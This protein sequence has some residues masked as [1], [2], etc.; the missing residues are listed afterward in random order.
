M[1]PKKAFQQ[2]RANAKQRGIPFEMTFDD[3]WGIWREWFHLRGRGTNGLC[4]ARHGDAGPY[5]VG[6]VYLTTNLGN[7]LDVHPSKR[8]IPDTT[9]SDDERIS[10]QIRRNR[11]G[12]KG[13][14]MS[15]NGDLK[16]HISFKASCE[17]EEV[18]QE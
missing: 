5:A 9:L 3:W 17:K 4:M 13:P 14:R 12:S 18:V 7:Q 15:F 16:S 11:W 6:N 1:T 2:H 8:K 10:R